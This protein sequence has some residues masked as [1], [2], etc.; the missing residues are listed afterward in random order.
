MADQESDNI[1]LVMFAAQTA[2]LAQEFDVSRRYCN[3]VL[4]QSSEEETRSQVDTGFGVGGGG[5]RCSD[6]G[7]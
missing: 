3:M 4:D 5:D 2:A 1:P 6:T 7:V